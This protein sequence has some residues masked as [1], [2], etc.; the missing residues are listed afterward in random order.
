VSRTRFGTSMQHIGKVAALSG[1]YYP[2][3]FFRPPPHILS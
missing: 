1:R 3:L 2:S